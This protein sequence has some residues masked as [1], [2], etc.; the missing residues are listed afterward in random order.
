MAVYKNLKREHLE[1]IEVLNSLKDKKYKLEEKKNVLLLLKSKI[2]K[3]IEIEDEHLYPILYARAEK[4]GNLKRLLSMFAS[5]MEQISSFI[6]NF[7]KTYFDDNVN[8]PVNLSKSIGRLL[9]MIKTRIRREEKI[10]FPEY[11]KIFS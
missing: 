9:V 7:Y 11:T 6:K 2:L 10:L 4:N 1:I 3:H 8:D 5:E